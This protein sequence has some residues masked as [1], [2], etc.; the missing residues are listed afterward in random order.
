MRICQGVDIVDIGKLRALLKRSPG[1]LATLF[2]ARELEYCLSHKDRY[3][4]LAGRF[5]AKE[6]CLK[7]LGL[8]LSPAGAATGLLEIEVVN[9]PSGR[10]DLY[11]HGWVARLCTR[12]GVRQRT[13][14]ISHTRD[15]AVATVVL[16]A[17]GTAPP[18]PPAAAG[19]Q[20]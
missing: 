3:P 14:S 2:T 9:H 1:L 13:V 6:A 5:A 7:A 20:E 10:P 16:L 17:A 12:T 18:T 19:S 15:Y 11:V 4:H 8:G